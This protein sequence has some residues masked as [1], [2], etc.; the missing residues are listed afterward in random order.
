V[1]DLLELETAADE[2]DDIV[3]CHAGGFIDEEYAVYFSLESH[4]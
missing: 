2:G 1:A 3:G 4:E